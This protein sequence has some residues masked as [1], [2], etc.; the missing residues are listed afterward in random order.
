MGNNDIKKGSTPNILI[1]SSGQKHGTI[2]CVHMDPF[3]LSGSMA[4]E[5]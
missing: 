1:S 4:M 2:S 3:K 5:L